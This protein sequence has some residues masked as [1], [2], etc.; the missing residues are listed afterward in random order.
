MYKYEL[1][2]NGIMIFGDFSKYLTGENNQELDLEFA[3]ITI[4]GV[5]DL[6]YSPD[7]LFIYNIEDY[8]WFWMFERNSIGN[9]TKTITIENNNLLI[10]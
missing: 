8:N 1:K 9:I 7:G 10:K 3:P 6:E 2:E 4:N 5:C